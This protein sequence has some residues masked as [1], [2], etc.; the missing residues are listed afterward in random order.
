MIAVFLFC[1][2]RFSSPIDAIGVSIVIIRKLFLSSFALKAR[3]DNH[4]QS[5]QVLKYRSR[6]LPF[7]TSVEP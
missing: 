2:N 3:N 1:F 4:F 5:F 6:G 7:K